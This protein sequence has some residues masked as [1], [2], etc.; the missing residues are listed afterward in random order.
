M[1]FEIVLI[2]LMFWLLFIL[3]VMVVIFVDDV[4]FCLLNIEL[5]LLV[6]DM[7]CL[8]M[9]CLMYNLGLEVVVDDML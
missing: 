3:G 1:F 4:E 6:L 9:I 7:W 2:L 8:L 5:V